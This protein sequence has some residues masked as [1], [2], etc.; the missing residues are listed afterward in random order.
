MSG[1]CLSAVAVLT[2]SAVAQQTGIDQ[3]REFDAY[4]AEGTCDSP[5]G[6]V[7]FDI[8]DVE[9]DDDRTYQ[10]LAGTP[11]S[12]PVFQEDE[13]ITATIADL[14]GSPHVV[15]VRVDDNPDAALVA[16]GEITGEPIDGTLQINLT[17]VDGSGIAGIAQFTPGPGDDDD[18]NDQ[19]QVVTQ[20]YADSATPVAAG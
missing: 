16:C 14:T 17:A 15:V 11:V 7:V 4:I 20:I 13:G 5:A 3:G 10:Q 8:G 19:T 1:I 2:G 12:G 9:A 18:D 6:Q